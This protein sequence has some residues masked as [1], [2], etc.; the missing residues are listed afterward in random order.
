LW[1]HFIVM[2]KWGLKGAKTLSITTFSIT[3]LS[4][5]TLGM[6]GLFATQ[7]KWQSAYS[8]ECLYAECGIFIL[9]FCELDH[10]I[11]VSDICCIAMKRSSLQERVRKLRRK[12]F[13]EIDPRNKKVLKHRFERVKFEQ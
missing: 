5:T 7:H 9:L 4:M 12:K 8:I 13:C 1:L 2:L 6:M 11:N 3:I 10:F